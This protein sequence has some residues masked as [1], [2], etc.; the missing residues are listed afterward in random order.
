MNLAQRFSAGEKATTHQSPVGTTDK[1]ME[2]PSNGSFARQCHIHYVFST[3]N[4]EKTITQ[5]M[6]PRLWAY[7]GGI[8]RENKRSPL[9][10]LTILSML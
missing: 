9:A 1:N 10:A 8:A 2:E 4:R 6:K 5:T 7:M 3:K